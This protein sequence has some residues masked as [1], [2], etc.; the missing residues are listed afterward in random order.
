VDGMPRL[1]ITL[2]ERQIIKVSKTLA[3]VG[4]DKVGS[5]AQSL[6]LDI[7]I[8]WLGPLGFALFKVFN[9]FFSLNSNLLEMGSSYHCLEEL[10]VSQINV[11]VYQSL[12][13]Y[14]NVLEELNRSPTNSVP[15]VTHTMMGD[16][17]A[18]SITSFL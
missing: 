2:M 8:L 15:Y 16:S 3:A 6:C 7:C 11:D 17:E 18:T 12:R 4:A 5:V 13:R 14:A 1:C 10:G 9:S